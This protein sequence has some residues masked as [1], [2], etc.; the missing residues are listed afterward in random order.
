VDDGRR[1]GAPAHPYS[2]AAFEELPPRIVGEDGRCTCTRDA[3][4]PLG[5]RGGQARCTLE[6]LRRCDREAVSR[7]AWQS[8]D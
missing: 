1:F 7:R 6:E 4:C 3:Y 8:G 2:L 5:R